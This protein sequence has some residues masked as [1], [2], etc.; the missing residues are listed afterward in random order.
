M[1]QRYIDTVQH[2]KDS[3]DQYLSYFNKNMM[4]K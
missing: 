3:G 1:Y 4:L 2:L